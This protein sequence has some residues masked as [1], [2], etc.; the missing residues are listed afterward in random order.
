MGEGT[1][2]NEARRGM[3]LEYSCTRHVRSSRQGTI[4]VFA[5]MIVRSEYLEFS[6]R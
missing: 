5:I 1:S 4:V 6:S 2:A 3:R